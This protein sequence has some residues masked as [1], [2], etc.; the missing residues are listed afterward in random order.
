VAS[1]LGDTFALLGSLLHTTMPPPL[2]SN[3]LML[4]STVSG[5]NHPQQF[6][7]PSIFDGV[8]LAP[9]GNPG[10][11]TMVSGGI[12]PAIPLPPATLTFPP[13]VPA[14]P[15][16][17]P[18]VVSAVIPAVA[19]AV[20]PTAPAMV[21]AVIPASPVPMAPF[22]APPV[23][24]VGVRAKRLKLN[25]MK[26]EKAFLDLLEQIHF[27]LQMPEFSTGHANCSL[28][29]DAE[30][31]EAG[32]AWEGQ[33][34]L[35]IKEGSLCFLFEKKGALK[36]LTLS[37]SIVTL[38]QSPTHSLVFS[39]SLQQCPVQ[40]KSI[41]EYCSRF[42]GLTLELARCKVV[43][44]SILL[45]MLF[46]HALHVWYD[47]ILNQFWMHFKPIETPT[48]NSI[49]SNVTY[50]DGYQVMDHSK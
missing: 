23:A 4:L 29:I 22:V 21:P 19:P 40:S 12:P 35:A 30:N 18:A 39:L 50:H 49:I 24:S 16:I 34:R 6:G 15:M 13:V 2:A 42:N 48:H 47:E 46:L 31:L 25:P 5:Y 9:G 11:I 27:Y 20:V 3:I 8:S 14:A 32:R 44:Q 1:L 41:I 45:V 37:C 38:T 28:T 26:D 43:I 10:G 33:L 7:R 36:F 17:I